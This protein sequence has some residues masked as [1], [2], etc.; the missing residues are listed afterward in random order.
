MPTFIGLVPGYGA[1]TITFDDDLTI[2]ATRYHL[3]G[4]RV[5]GVVVAVPLL[6]TPTQ[7]PGTGRLA[8]VFGDGPPPPPGADP[9]TFR[10]RVD[11]PTANGLRL[12]GTTT[13]EIARAA[14]AVRVS[15]HDLGVSVTRETPDGARPAPAATADRVASVLALLARHFSHRHLTVL[16]RL[17]TA[18]LA[19]LDRAAATRPN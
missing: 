12:T 14:P 15:T 7:Q 17:H 2:G 10:R 6:D 13:V 3:S 8:M 16:A 18:R 4:P 5:H 19:A 1:S 9:D 11:R